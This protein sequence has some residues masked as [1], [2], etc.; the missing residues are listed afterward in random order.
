MATIKVEDVYPIT[1]RTE[2]GSDHEYVFVTDDD[3]VKYTPP[4]KLD[5]LHNFL[6]GQTRYMW[7]T[8]PS[9]LEAW[10]NKKPNLD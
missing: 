6:N 7:G 3:L 9:D 2:P 10:L 8:Y 1:R 5:E 4:V